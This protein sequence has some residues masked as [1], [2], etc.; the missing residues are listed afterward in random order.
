[1]SKIGI[2]LGSGLNK[3][4]SELKEKK[5]IFEDSKGI[6]HKKI[7]SGYIDNKQVF[8]FEGRNHYFENPGENKLFF[9]ISTGLGFGIDLFIITN[10]AG[11]LNNA[12]SVT[13]LMIIDS[14]IDMIHHKF[15]SKSLSQFYDR[16]TINKVKEL[17][18][19]N[20]INLRTG[21]YCCCT[22]P[23]YETPAEIH[24]YKKYNIDAMGMS[25][26]PEM[27]FAVKNGAKVIAISCITN[28]LL[29]KPGVSVDHSDVLKAGIK[30]YGNFSKLLKLIINDC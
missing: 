14:H 24:Y 26:I 4:S 17:A 8:I 21:T 29:E 1:M 23:V 15:N 10:A 3:F 28:I 12:F 9:N 5:L 6:H 22:G 30:S 19:K 13:D 20:N 18:Y 25:T 16:D 7:Y 2:I 27:K 11:G